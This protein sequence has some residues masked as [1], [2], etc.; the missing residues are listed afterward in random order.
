MKGLTAKQRRILDFIREEVGLKNYPP[1]VREICEKMNLSSS[2][3]VHAHLKALE[4]KG[5]IKRDSTKPRAL[6]LLDPAQKSER[7]KKPRSVPLVGRVSS[8]TPLLAA[9]NIESYMTLPENVAKGEVVFLFRV[10]GADMV[11]AGIL[12][13]D[14]LIVREQA[15]AENGEIV[16]ALIEEEEAAVKRYYRENGQ[17]R[18]QPDN[19][20][21]KTI[22]TTDNGRIRILG[23]VI[24]LLRS[25]E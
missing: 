19:H 25:F 22:T 13:G 18:L 4:K 24:G 17:I 7:E 12:E 16:V 23:R 1:S 21:N 15:A 3:T 6:E 11:G 9:E 14:L 8:G 2:S 10:N 20:A 5:Y